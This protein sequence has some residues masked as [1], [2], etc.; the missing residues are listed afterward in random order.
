VDEKALKALED[1]GYI[2]LRVTGS[3]RDVVAQFYA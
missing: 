1:A 3:P 2:V